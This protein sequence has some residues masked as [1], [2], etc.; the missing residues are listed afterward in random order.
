MKQKSPQVRQR[1]K[2]L[3]LRDRVYQIAAHL[4]NTEESPAGETLM[5][6]CEEMQN[7]ANAMQHGQQGGPTEKRLQNKLV[8]LHGRMCETAAHLV[9]TRQTHHGASLRADCAELQDV[10]GRMNRGAA[11]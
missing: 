7:I 9:N 2:L 3:E 8:S 6:D 11:E 5:N 4:A 10:I 1:N